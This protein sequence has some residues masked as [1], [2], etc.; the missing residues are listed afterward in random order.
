MMKMP[1]L[2]G[3]VL[4]NRRRHAHP[5]RNGPAPRRQRVTVVN[6]FSSPFGRFK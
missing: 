6:K 4:T 1:F 5:F 3:G 2:E